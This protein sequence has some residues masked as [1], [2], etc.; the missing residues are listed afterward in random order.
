AAACLRAPA[1]LGQGRVLGDIAELAVAVVVVQ[2]DSSPVRDGQVIVAIVVIVADAASLSPSGSNEPG[3]LSHV[4]EGSVA[5]VV[6]EK[7][8][9]LMLRRDAFEAPAIDA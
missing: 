2:N 1:F 6:K 7:I 9:G 8:R 3:L 4:G 5:I